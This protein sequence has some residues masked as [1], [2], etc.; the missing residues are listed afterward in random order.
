M[1]GPVQ[2]PAKRVARA[3]RHRRCRLIPGPPKKKINDFDLDKIYGSDR[4]PLLSAPPSRVWSFAR[5]PRTQ[6]M[7]L[8]IR[9]PQPMTGS[10]RR[11]VILA[12]EG[13]RRHTAEPIG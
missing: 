4:R 3:G 9:L 2:R 10:D 12:L 5:S 7:P 6:A 1:E 11:S 13:G 8:S